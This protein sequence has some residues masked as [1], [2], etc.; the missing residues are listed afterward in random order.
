MNREEYGGPRRSATGRHRRSAIGAHPTPAQALPVL[1]R[2]RTA[3]RLTTNEHSA[4]IGREFLIQQSVWHARCAQESV[5]QQPAPPGAALHG[6]RSSFRGM[7][8][9]GPRAGVQLAETPTPNSLGMSRWRFGDFELDRLRRQLLHRG[10]PVRLEPRVLELLAYLAANAGRVVSKDELLAEVWGTPHVTDWAVS[11]AIAEVRKVLRKHDPHTDWIKTFYG[12]GFQ[13]LELVQALA[14]GDDAPAAIA[15]TPKATAPRLRRPQTWALAMALAG[16]LLVLWYAVMIRDQSEATRAGP[17][18]PRVVVVAPAATAELPAWLHDG[19]VDELI[20]QLAH[21]AELRVLSRGAGRQLAQANGMAADEAA[22]LGA[23]FALELSL[24]DDAS[25]VRVSAQLVRTDDAVVLWSEQYA[26]VEQVHAVASRIAVQVTAMV[27]GATPETAIGP[28][29]VDSEAEIAFLRGRHFLARRGTG[30][31]DLALQFFTTATSIDA[32]HAPAWAGKASAYALQRIYYERPAEEAWKLAAAAAEQAI[33]LNPELA[34]AHAVLGLLALNADWDFDRARAH[35]RRALALAPSHTQTLQWS[36]ELEMLSG[37]YHSALAQIRLACELDP[38]SPLLIG[39]WGTILATAGDLPGA[40][41]KF[42]EALRM[43][44]E[45]VWLQ[46][47]L[48]YI[49]EHGGDSASAMQAR[50][51]EMQLRGVAASDLQALDGAMATDGLIGFRRWYLDHLGGAS[52]I[53]ASP[54][55]EL[56]VETLAALGEH[57]QAERILRQQ[58]RQMGEGILHFWTRSPAFRDPRYRALALELGLQQLV[59]PES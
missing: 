29:Q 17:V 39:I 58:G 51:T 56:V 3:Y 18:P 23:D 44:P 49:A 52:G 54:V 11:R 47:E 6:Q 1:A 8:G 28:V 30:D 57:N 40:Q 35:Y 42:V 14:E 31:L 2:H 12:R 21:Q 53:V 24:R 7:S 10:E 4:G 15:Q 50:R 34:D 20:S 45:F 36:A 19:L 43:D 16:I 33:D 37:H 46:R 26:S 41:Q 9:R 55:P 32:H 25:G 38:V 48:A 59:I 13:M 22:A 5:D 27:T